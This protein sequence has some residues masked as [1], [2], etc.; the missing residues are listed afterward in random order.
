MRTKPVRYEDALAEP[1]RTPAEFG[2]RAGIWFLP[3]LHE[4]LPPTIFF[5]VGFNLVVLTTNLILAQYSVAFANFMLATA[6]ALR[7]GSADPADSLQDGLLLGHR[8]PRAFQTPA[9]S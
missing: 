6:A 4:I 1:T 7:S 5:L 3:A 9:S 8:V 2:R